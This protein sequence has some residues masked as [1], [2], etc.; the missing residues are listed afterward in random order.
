MNLIDQ[1]LA[2]A[3]RKN[4]EQ[5]AGSSSGSAGANSEPATRASTDPSSWPGLVWRVLSQLRPWEAQFWR[6]S[7]HVLAHKRSLVALL[8]LLFAINIAY[9]VMRSAGY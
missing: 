3:V 9:G 2:E 7:W 4:A 1:P 6:S 8:V 5:I